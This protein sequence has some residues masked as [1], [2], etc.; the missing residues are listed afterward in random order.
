MTLDLDRHFAAVTRTVTPQERD[1]QRAF[2]VTLSRAF[3]EAREDVWEAVTSADR[4]PRWFLPITGELTPGGRF[5][6]EGQ[7]GGEIKACEPGAHLALTWEFAGD[8]SWVDVTVEDAG[9]DGVRLTLSH[10]QL[11]S[12]FWDHYGPGATGVGWETAFAGL[13]MHLEEPDTFRPDAE[14]FLMSEEGQAYIVSCS[15]AWGSAA[16]AAG[17][18]P[19]AAD[20][21]ARRTRAFYTGQEEPAE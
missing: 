17:D 12:P 1:G 8:V 11:H 3:K 2:A 21:A 4:I 16:T 7:A 15:E 19:A 13:A 5:Q 10:A 18:D 20:L 9:A 6:L 14:A